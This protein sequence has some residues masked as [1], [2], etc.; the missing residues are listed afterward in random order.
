MKKISV[1]GDVMNE[2][3]LGDTC[4]TP[5][6]GYD[7]SAVF[8]PLKG[9]LSKS[10]YRIANLESP[11]AGEKLGYS[12]DFYSFNAPDALVEALK[13]IGID[14]VSTANNHA[15]DRGAEGFYNTLDALDR[16]SMPHTGTFRDPDEKER[17]FYFTVGD[18][19]V[20]MIA[21]TYAI[22]A[23]IK[24]GVENGL[25]NDQVNFL[26]N[27]RAPFPRKHEPEYFTQAIKYI[28]EVTGHTLQ[29]R[30]TLQLKKILGIPIPYK[31]EWPT[32]YT[33]PYLEKL[34]GYYEEARKNADIVICVPHIGGQFN[35]EPGSFSY[36]C[37][38]KIMEMGF[39]GVFA[40]HSHTTQKAA[41][42]D[43]RPAFYSLGNVS[44]SGRT[45]YAQHQTLP[46]IGL[47]AHLYVDGGK[48]A[49]TAFSLF[50]I[51][52]KGEEQMRVI[53]V[54]ELYATLESED[55]KAS[56]AKDVAEVVKR[57]SGKEL[58]GADA[59]KEEYELN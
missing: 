36:Y 59:I 26:T 56:L 31:D 57:V 16:L 47:I 2:S 49:K 6:G 30:E 53:P 17:V 50:K 54:N 51:Y 39:D 32:E 9:I 58:S 10:D 8:A 13:A 48:I 46:S 1:I 34:K 52:E 24:N 45:P 55:E 37:M 33:A 42:F 3:T 19:K 22:N 38:D 43:G 4:K 20:A 15:V 23:W 25:S 29:F 12:E 44:M 14:V 21:C 7:Y 40:A 11:V 41:L 27:P 5:D 28:N 18:T 35:T